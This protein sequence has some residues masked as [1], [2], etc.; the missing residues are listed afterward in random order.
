MGE[1]AASA[2]AAI[3]DLRRTSPD[4]GIKRKAATAYRKITGRNP[5]A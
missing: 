2:A 3:L 5:P 1:Q 4:R